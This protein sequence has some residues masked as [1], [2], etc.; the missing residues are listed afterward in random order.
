MTILLDGEQDRG[1]RRRAIGTAQPDTRVE[2][3][4]SPGTPARP[5]APGTG[6]GH[7]G[8]RPPRPCR[9]VRVP[10]ARTRARRSPCPSVCPGV[11]W[12]T[13]VVG[14]VGR[15]DA[16][17]RVEHDQRDL[18]R[19]DDVARVVPGPLGVHDL[20]AKV[21]DVHQREDGAV[22]PS[23]GGRGGAGP[24][25]G[26]SGRSGPGPPPP[27]GSPPRI[28]RAIQRSRS[29]AWIGRSISPIRRPTSAGRSPRAVAARLVKRR[30]RR[31]PSR[32]TMGISTA[33]SRF[34]RSA[35]T[36]CEVLVP[37]V[38]LV[39][40]GGELLVGGLE[41]L[42]GGLQLLVEALQLLVARRPARRWP[43]R[44]R[45]WRARAPRAG[46]RRTPSWRPAPPRAP[47]RRRRR[48]A[49]PRAFR[50]AP[51]RGGGTLL[52]ER[53]GTPARR[54]PRRSRGARRCRRPGRRW[55][56]RSGPAPCGP[57]PTSGAPRPARCAAGRRARPAPS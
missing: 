7:R 8:W 1:S 33:S 32:I 36:T 24:G 4:R 55:T 20:V 11:S 45:R 10:L 46:R 19:L 13:P 54:R 42:L 41:L 16:Q 18:H 9:S 49:R 23:V 21:V 2:R 22:G 56:G 3:F 47:G 43:R 51:R 40:D 28:E 52:E 44:A 48:R 57:A 39:V 35:L 34:T 37:A 29:G 17:P 27:P 38:E 25:A 30:M 5:P 26:A 31:F 53:R 14:R 50:A 6:P 12:K 15:E